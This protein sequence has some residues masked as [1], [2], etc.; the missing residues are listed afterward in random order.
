MI[1]QSFIDMFKKVFGLPDAILELN[2]YGQTEYQVEE[3]CP[4]EIIYDVDYIV[5]EFN[6]RFKKNWENAYNEQKLPVQPEDANVTCYTPWSFNFDWYGRYIAV[7]SL[8][9]HDKNRNVVDSELLKKAFCNTVDSI[10]ND[11]SYIVNARSLSERINGYMLRPYDCSQTSVINPI[12]KDCYVASLAYIINENVDSHPRVTKKA[13]QALY[14]QMDPDAV[15]DIYKTVK[16]YQHLLSTRAKH[17]LIPSD[18]IMS[19]I[20]L[21]DKEPDECELNDDDER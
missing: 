14:S 18:E 20:G 21:G 1:T 12:D 13:M 8:D 17:L 5:E 4:P 15:R 9:F 10:R 19:Q 2:E 11:F 16:D 7:E 3:G 6:K